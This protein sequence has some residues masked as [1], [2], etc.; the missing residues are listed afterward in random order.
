MR[1]IKPDREA[2]FRALFTDTYPD[3]L[4]FAQRRVHP[5]HAEDVTATSYRLRLL[6]AR[7][8]LRRAL[9]PATEATGLAD[10]GLDTTNRMETRP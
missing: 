8:A 10:L 5:S 2:R 3:V 6:R 9:H 4:R 7:R 1:T